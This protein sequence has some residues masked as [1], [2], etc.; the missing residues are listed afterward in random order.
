[1]S[2]DVVKLLYPYHFQ[3]SLTQNSFYG[4]QTEGRFASGALL[5]GV[6]K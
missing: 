4:P 2:P 5:F 3:L 6:K 1:M